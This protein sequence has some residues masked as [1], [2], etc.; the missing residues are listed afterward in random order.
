MDLLVLSAGTGTSG[1]IA[2]YPM[3]RFDRQLTVNLRAPGS[4]GADRG[5]RL[6]TRHRR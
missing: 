2:D 4:R 3:W 1:R 5:G 6:D